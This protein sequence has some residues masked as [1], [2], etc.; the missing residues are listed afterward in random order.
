M[1]LAT[2]PEGT[3][4][5]FLLEECGLMALCSTWLNGE[6]AASSEQPASTSPFPHTGTLI[7]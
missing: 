3:L 1:G 5:G 6:E 2:Y 4:C 7:P